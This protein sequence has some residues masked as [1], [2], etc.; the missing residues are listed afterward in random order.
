MKQDR[1]LAA[2]MF[3]DIVGSTSMMQKDESLAV[4]A[5]TKHKKVIE[6]CAKNHE[7]EVINFYGD[8][9]MSIFSSATAV[10][11]CAMSIQRHMHEE[12][13]VPLRIGIHIGEILVQD[14]EVF[15]DGVNV[16]SRIESLGQPGTVLFSEEVFRKIRNNKQFETAQIGYFHFKNVD[17][18]MAVYALA[19]EGFPVPKKES[20]TGKLEHGNGEGKQSGSTGF[21][22]KKILNIFGISGEKEKVETTEKPD[23]SIAVLPFEKSG[24]LGEQEV[25]ADGLADEIR[26]RLLGIKDLKVISRSSSMHYKGKNI[27]LKKVG[28]DLGV[29]YVLEGRVQVH[30][31]NAVIHAELSHVASDKMIWSMPAITMSEENIINLQSQIANRVVDELKLTLTPEEKTLL[32]RI[33]TTNPDAFLQF[34]KGQDMLH[35]GF[36]FKSELTQATEHF[37][38]AVELDPGFTKAWIGLADSYLE[39]VFWGRATA[40]EML[41]K[42]L[43]ACMKALELAPESGE[44]WGGLGSIYF[45]K[46]EKDAARKYLRKAIEL[47]PGYIEAYTKLGWISTHDED[48]EQALYYFSKA[49]SLDP[50]STKFLGDM[51]QAYYFKGMYDEGLT[52]IESTLKEHPNDSWLLWIQGFLYT[53]KQDFHKA[54]EVLK[55]RATGQTNWLLGYAY[56]KVGDKEKALE[57]LEYNLKK[58]EEDFV[59]AHMIASIYLGLGDHKKALDYLELDF[60]EGALSQLFWNLG[61]EPM[62]RDIQDEPRFQALMR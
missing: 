46:S 58:R 11:E 6:N 19:N 37:K 36:G 18:P 20:V 2:I 45:Y 15:G 16:A 44:A 55:Q 28:K 5:V 38:K 10:L 13:A 41:D 57:I 50:L 12:P 42:A 9:S 22:L 29:S 1:R 26:S 31:H 47:S 7:G 4:L 56:G 30:N 48:I 43:T 60:K 14:G 23:H 52:F 62:F 17:E 59:P 8:G 49:H 24:N 53:G 35:R 51:G 61:K 21:S 33:P 39:H 34:Q 25:I 40:T 27:P 54:I 3:T 32:N